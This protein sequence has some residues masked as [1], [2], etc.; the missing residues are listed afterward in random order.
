MLKLCKISNETYDVLKF[1]AMTFLPGLATMVGTIGVALGYPQ[2][3]GIIVTV[4]SAVGAFIGHC[5]GLSNIAYKQNT[6]E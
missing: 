1:I 4:I 3:T 2:M 5:V 6:E